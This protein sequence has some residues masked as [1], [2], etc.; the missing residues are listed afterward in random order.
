MRLVD[1]DKPILVFAG[2]VLPG[3]SNDSDELF[4]VKLAKDF[5]VTLPVKIRGFFTF[6]ATPQYR[7]DV[8]IAIANAGGNISDVD[9]MLETDLIRVV[10]PGHNDISLDA[11]SGIKLVPIG[12]K[13]KLPKIDE[14][15]S[16]VY[17]GHSEDATKVCPI[18]TLLAS[19]LWESEQKE[20]FPNAVRRLG[21][22]A[23]LRGDIV[24]RL[25]LSDLD[26]LLSHGL[27]R[28][29]N[30][31]EPKQKSQQR[32]LEEVSGIAPASSL[33]PLDRIRK[34]LLFR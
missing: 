18:S 12:F 1:Q 7:D 9:R 15:S 2:H 6:M 23:G 27:A 26:G 10:P 17:V 16:L 14:A 30:L 24:I 29:E 8:Y 32:V 22:E 11:L 28:W 3:D 25:A 5:V 34:F 21:I 31:V 13:V 19:V 4:Q 20:D 33:S